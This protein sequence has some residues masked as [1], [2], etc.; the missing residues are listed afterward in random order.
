MPQHLSQSIDIEAGVWYVIQLHRIHETLLHLVE[1]DD[2]A[3]Q[4]QAH[5][6]ETIDQPPPSDKCAAPKESVLEGLD[7]WSHRIQAH[8]SM[9]RNSH[10]THA[11]SLAQR[12]DD[13]CRIHPKLDQEAEEYL[14][15]A[16]F[17][18]H[19]GNDC[20]ESQRQTGHHKD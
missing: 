14:Q 13:W 17:G 12:I 3:A 2:T 5:E 19:R 11:S 20:S 10:E 6:N 18:G 15:V 8:E 7:D 1:D 4:K 9:D 16:V